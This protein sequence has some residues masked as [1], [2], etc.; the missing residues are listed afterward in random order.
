MWLLQDGRF[1]LV[2]YNVLSPYLANI[3]SYPSVGAAL[4]DRN[5]RYK[6]VT[7]KVRGPGDRVVV[8]L[9]QCAREWLVRLATTA[10]L[11][12]LCVAW[13]DLRWLLVR[14]LVVQLKEEMKQS[15]VI[16]LQEMS[17]SWNGPFATLCASKVRD[18]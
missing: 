4:L 15:S 3:A 17:L 7:D 9:A 2:N 8:G 11:S 13:T 12:Q 6:A 5:Y 18:N 16:A 10:M 1:R 14:T